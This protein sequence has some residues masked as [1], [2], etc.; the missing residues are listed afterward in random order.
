MEDP[1]TRLFST[2]ALGASLF[3]LPITAA[4]SDCN[5]KKTAEAAPVTKMV[6]ADNAYI[7]TIGSYAKKD[8]VDTAASYDTFST[9]VAAGKAADLVDTLKS[10]GPFTVFAPT[11]AAFD[12]LPAGT[13]E[14]LLLPENKDQLV[15]VLT[16]H[17]VPAKVMSTDLSD[18]ANAPTVQGETVM[19]DLSDGVR[20]NNANVVKADIKTSN[21]V[22]HVIDAVLLPPALTN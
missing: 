19:V 1:M 13:V 17:V 15:S 18:G 2:L 12:A 8:I 21:G 7:Q 9:L 10:E 4:A 16:Y 22:I 11:N 5:Y 14:S 6:S 20:I 3:A